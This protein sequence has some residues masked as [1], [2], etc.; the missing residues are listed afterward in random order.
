MVGIG[1][2]WRDIAAKH[3]KDPILQ[4]ILEGRLGWQEHQKQVQGGEG[5]AWGCSHLDGKPRANVKVFFKRRNSG[6]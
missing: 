3:G 6:I 4:T 2:H 5:L 1:S